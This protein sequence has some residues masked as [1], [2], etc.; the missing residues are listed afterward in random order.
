MSASR[1]KIECCVSFISKC[2]NTN[3]SS[4]ERQAPLFVGLNGAQGSGKT[5]LVSFTKLTD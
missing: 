4:R 5:H 2:Y 3:V 1:D